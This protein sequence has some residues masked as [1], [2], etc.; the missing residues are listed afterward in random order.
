MSTINRFLADHWVDSSDDL[1]VVPARAQL[2]TTITKGS[3]TPPCI[4]FTG[5]RSVGKTTFAVWM[6]RSNLCQ[7]KPTLC[8][9]QNRCAS[10][11][12]LQTGLHPD[13]LIITPEDDER[14]IGVEQS[15]RI[16]DFFSV[17]SWD[18]SH[19][20][21]LIV[22][23]ELLTAEASTA[24][25]KLLEELGDHARIILTTPSPER[26]LST[27]RSRVP[28]IRWLRSSDDQLKRW[29]QQ[30]QLQSTS[31]QLVRARG[32]P[33]LIVTTLLGDHW[34]DPGTDLTIQVKQFSDILQSEDIQKNPQDAQLN[35][36]EII[37]WYQLLLERVDL[38]TIHTIALSI[39][40]LERTRA[41]LSRHGP[42]STLLY[43][44]SAQLQALAGNRT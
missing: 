19:R 8:G 10:C 35:V 9:A 42:I 39:R 22:G 15:R 11:R 18:G 1:C 27:V 30:H 40:Q 16:V 37:S 31:S 33:G 34:P 23:A 44:C 24:L 2:L 29:V 14:S 17:R 43:D 21:A 3:F 25:L 5:P 26:L 36:D 13:V 41:L 4:L 6:I 38:P 12:A 20:W 28:C 7:S 32:C